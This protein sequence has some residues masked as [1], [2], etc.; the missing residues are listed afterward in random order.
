MLIFTSLYLES[1]F[2]PHA[3]SQRIRQ[4]NSIQFYATLEKSATGTPA[5]IRQTRKEEILSRT[6]KFQ[7]HRYRIRRDR[8]RGKSRA[9]SLF[10]FTS[11]VLFTK[12]SSW[13]AKQLLPHTTLTFYDDCVKTCEDFATNFGTKRWLLHHDNAPSRASSFTSE[14]LTRNN[15]TSVPHPPYFSVSTIEDSNAGKFSN[16]LTIHRPY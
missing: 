16:S 8:W 9:C 10:S 12:N 2:C 1:C 11:R 13:Q 14:F 3:I 15:I 7:T 6:R 4:R 5:K